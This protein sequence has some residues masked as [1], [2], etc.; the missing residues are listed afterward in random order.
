[1]IKICHLK[2]DDL[3]EV[4]SFTDRWIGDG[5]YGLEQLKNIFE[6][7]VDQRYQGAGL[8]KQLS[9]ASLKVIHELGGVLERN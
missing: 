9:Q 5:Y 6:L 4:K 3:P 2:L 7:L 1:M 8:G